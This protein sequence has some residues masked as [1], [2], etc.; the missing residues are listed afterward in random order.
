MQCVASNLRPS[1]NG[2]PLHA[3]FGSSAWQRACVVGSGGSG[4]Q[5]AEDLREAGRGVF[6]AVRRHRRMPRRYRG[7][8]LGW[9]LERSGMTEYTS[10]GM[11]PDWRNSKAPLMTG[12]RGGRTVD[13]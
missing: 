3:T 5:I 2:K 4:C 1:G 6:Y 9:W 11:P 10:E 7:Q 13:L 12:V 8:D